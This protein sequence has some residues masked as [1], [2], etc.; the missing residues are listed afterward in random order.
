MPDTQRRPVRVPPRWFVRSAWAAHRALYRITG[1]RAGL[2]PP[3]AG[4]WGALRLTTTGRR[5]GRPRSVIIAYLQDGPNLV[6]MAM[7]GWSD[8]E[9]AWWL[10]LRSRPEATVELRGGRRTVRARAA[11]GTERALLW[12][13]WRELD[14]QLDDY[15]ALRSSPTTVVI[16]EPAPDPGR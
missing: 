7:N 13:R 14:A 1:H 16:L 4:R 5:T 8:G 11:E 9:P 6:A 15:A 10:N 2:W 12:A 3:R